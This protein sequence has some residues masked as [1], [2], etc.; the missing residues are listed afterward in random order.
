MSHIVISATGDFELRE[1]APSSDD[2]MRLV[3]DGSPQMLDTFDDEIVL[4]VNDDYRALNRRGEIERNVLG[5]LVCVMIRPNTGP[6]AG[7]M[8]LTG[9][10]RSPVDGWSAKDLDV[11]MSEALMSS[12]QDMA[13]VVFGNVEPAMPELLTPDIRTAFLLAADTARQAPFPEESYEISVISVDDFL[14][15]LGGK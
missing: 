6:V 15:L 2:L 13:S 7:P 5:S 10:D 4:W 3:G 9:I 8:I 1:G 12:L 11:P 14:R